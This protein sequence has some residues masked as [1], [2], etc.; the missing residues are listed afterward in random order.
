MGMAAAAAAAAHAHPSGGAEDS[1][2]TTGRQLRPGLLV[3][4]PGAGHRRADDTRP[5][6]DS[7]RRC[8]RF[9]SCDANAGDMRSVR[10]MRAL[11]RRL[12]CR[13]CLPMLQCHMAHLM[14]AGRRALL[15]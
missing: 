7:L 9:L 5:N 15:R 10:A 13:L 4:M 14:A 6:Y 12:R 3:A 11:R 1:G 2:H 8:L